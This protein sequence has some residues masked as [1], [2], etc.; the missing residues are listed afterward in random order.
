M[1]LE[2]LTVLPRS[3]P[4][5]CKYRTRMGRELEGKCITISAVLGS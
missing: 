5:F 1:L 3:V 4:L 2:K